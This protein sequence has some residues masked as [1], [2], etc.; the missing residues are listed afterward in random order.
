[1]KEI[2]FTYEREV[3][4]IKIV[5]KTYLLC[6]RRKTKREER[7]ETDTKEGGGGGETIRV[8]RERE[9]ER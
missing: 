2:D 8:C 7:K 3:E 1:M 6:R 9:R 4:I 5:K